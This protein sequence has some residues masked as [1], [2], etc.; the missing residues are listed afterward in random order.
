MAIDHEERI[1]ALEREMTTV[2]SELT[3]VKARLDAVG[4]DM[5][6]IPDLIRVEFRFVNSQIASQMARLTHQVEALPRAVAELVTEM[7][8][9]RDGSR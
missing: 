6:N 4:E 7:L 2:K 1:S 5:R 8:R 3:D 9:E